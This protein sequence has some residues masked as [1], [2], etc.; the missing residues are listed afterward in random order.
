VIAWELGGLAF[1]GWTTI[2]LFDLG[3]RPAALLAGALAVLWLLGSWRIMR[4][5]V[6]LSEHGVR[7]RGLVGSRTLRWTQIESFALDQVVHRLGQFELPAGTTV[8]IRCH[9][10]RLVK[11]PLWAQGIDFHARPGAF[12]DVYHALRERHL[13][14]LA[15]A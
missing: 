3:P 5:G 6:Y 4:I 1:V 10:G 15:A 14:A 13:A 7:V 8:R 11:T 9:D 2:R 12:R